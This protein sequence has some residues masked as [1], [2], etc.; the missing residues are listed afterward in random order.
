MTRTLTLALG[1]RLLVSFSG[2][3]EPDGPEYLFGDNLTGLEFTVYTTDVGIYPDQSVLDDPNNTF[4]DQPPLND[5]KWDLHATAGNVP[6]FYGWA[7]MLAY[8]PI[9]ENQYF[10]A[11]RLRDI[12]Y[13][14][15]PPPGYGPVVRDMALRGFQSVLD[16]FPDSLVFDASGTVGFRLAPLAYDGIIEL[17]GTVEGNWVVVATD[18]DGNT[19]VIQDTGAL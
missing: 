4:G 8:E 5:L 7:T 17:G 16:N 13:R 2:C 18:E 19:T 11:L 3:T 12:Y 6:A 9:G 1:A 15:D 14:G 10:A